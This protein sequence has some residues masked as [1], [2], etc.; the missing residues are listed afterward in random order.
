MNSAQGGTE[1]EQINC[2]HVVLIPKFPGA[3]S[4]SS[5]RTISLKKCSVKILTKIPTRRLQRQINKLV[6]TDQTGFLKGGS[7]SENFTYATELI[8]CCY[9]RKVPTIVLKLDFAKALF[10]LSFMEQPDRHHGSPPLPE[11]LVSLD[12]AP[13]V[14]L[15]VGNIGQWKHRAMDHLQ[16]WS[17]PRRYT[18]PIPLPAGG[19][20]AAE[21][22]LFG[23]VRTRLATPRFCLVGCAKS[24]LV[25]LSP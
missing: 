13:A 16:K 15:K 8:Q 7:I 21:T 22:P 18:F 4:P 12:Q 11:H 23:C 24:A 10:R 25:T 2:A 19:Q 9:H 3:S 14:H 17:P 5:F 20:R 6:D 1:L